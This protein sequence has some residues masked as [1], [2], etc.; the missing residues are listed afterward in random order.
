MY[1]KKERG[2]E[3]TNL[4]VYLERQIA[5][6]FEMMYYTQQLTMKYKQHN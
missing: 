1:D 3:Y 2:I 6:L 4:L 5:S